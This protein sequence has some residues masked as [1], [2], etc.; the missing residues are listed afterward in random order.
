M[1]SWLTALSLSCHR[2]WHEHTGSS[3]VTTRRSLNAESVLTPAKTRYSHVTNPNEADQA[4]DVN[5]V[6]SLV[7]PRF[8]SRTLPKKRVADISAMSEE[9][10]RRSPPP[11]S[12]AEEDD[13]EKVSWSAS[14]FEVAS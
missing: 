1:Y 6:L 13:W 8:P 3:L 7:N 2:P 5:Q 14:I 9:V 10:A 12:E 11:R 4:L